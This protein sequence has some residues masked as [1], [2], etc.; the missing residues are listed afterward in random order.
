[1]N[2]NVKSILRRIAA[3]AAALFVGSSLLF[4]ASP[5]TAAP[6][7]GAAS[8]SVA[9]GV[10]RMDAGPGHV[11]IP[12]RY[13]YNPNTTKQKTLH[14]YCTKSPDSFRAA[15]FRGPCARHDLCIMDRVKA[16]ST[17][18]SVFLSNLRQ[19]CNHTYDRKYVEAAIRAT[20]N[21]TAYSYYGVVRKKTFFS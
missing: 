10:V 20:C 2:K 19:E 14:D 11:T 9:A 3:V 7:A 4:G 8:A 1:M 21:A 18:D 12:S 15:D 13:V 5:A 16:R 6:S 17:C